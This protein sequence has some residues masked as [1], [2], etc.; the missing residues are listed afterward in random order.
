MCIKIKSE[1]I[2]RTKNIVPDS[3]VFMLCAYYSFDFEKLAFWRRHLDKA[4][5]ID[6][7]GCVCSKIVVEELL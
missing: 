3:L 7:R 4:I 2:G 1:L 6:Y 5:Q